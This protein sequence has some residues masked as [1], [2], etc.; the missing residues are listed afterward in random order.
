LD[1]D[2]ENFGPGPSRNQP[3]DCP[4]PLVWYEIASGE[5]ADEPTQRFIQHATDCEHCG[6]LLG[7]AVSDL[8]KE[9]TAA[10][11][12]QIAD[13]ESARPDWQH[14]LAHRIAGTLR[15]ETNQ[16]AAWL[17]WRT[18]PRLALTTAGLLAALIAGY[19]YEF[20]RSPEKQVGQLLA[21][22]GS[23]RRFSELRF[24]GSRY[25]SLGE[26][27]KREPASTFLSSPG[28]LLKAEALIYDQLGAHPS[29]PFWLR[30]KARADLLDGKYDAA[31]AALRRAWQLDPKSPEI[32]TDLATA[33]FQQKDYAAAYETLSQALS[34][35][36]DDPLALFNRAVVSENQFLYRQALEDWERYL[37]VDSNSQWAVEARERS[38]AVRK[39][40]EKHDQSRASPLLTPAQLVES[41]DRS[42]RRLQVDERIEEYLTEAV[43]SWLPQT[44]PD[45]AGKADPA[46]RQALFFLADLTTRRHSDAWLS[47]L[48]RHSSSTDFP[49]ALAGLAR[50]TRA[51][52]P[53]D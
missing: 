17:R 6:R 13:L 1:R 46:T 45:K 38:E 10:E 48:L 53:G 26:G 19:W 50:A 40:L 29:D 9:T 5:L 15:P 8:N 21:Q 14:H 28:E 16:E 49:P 42:E 4:D 31:Q 7:D 34:L 47:D 43:I 32:L 30:A 11:A 3:L 24:E 36:P 35:R 25:A 41:G 44:Y 18:A 27:L 20:Q 51:N 33:F 23:A 12:K 22:A 37:K 39:K 52:H 2:S